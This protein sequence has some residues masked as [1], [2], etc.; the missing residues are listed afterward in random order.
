MENLKVSKFLCIMGLLLCRLFEEKYIHG[1]RFVCLSVCQYVMKTY[2][3]L[4]YIAYD[5]TNMVQPNSSCQGQG[6]ICQS[7]APFCTNI[8][9]NC[10]F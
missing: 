8:V 6:H 5:N 4:F 2:R 9:Y 3:W 1:D 7:F 10:H